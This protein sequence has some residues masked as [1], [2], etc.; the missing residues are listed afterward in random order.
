[1]DNQILKGVFY[2]LFIS[3]IVDF[4]Q[5]GYFIFVNYKLIDIAS[6]NNG[7][8]SFT[9]FILCLA[10]YALSDFFLIANMVKSIRS[11]NLDIKLLS[12]VLVNGLSFL[13]LS[14]FKIILKA[15]EFKSFAPPYASLFMALGAV[16]SLVILP[17]IWLYMDAITRKYV[18]R[19]NILDFE[20]FEIKEESSLY[21]TY[22]CF[23]K[24]ELDGKEIVL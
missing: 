9:R 13:S 16:I 3:K 22:K 20:I 4:A 6:L 12:G 11:N 7:E 14:L 5:F 1:M 8:L 2:F 19:K 21:P 10:F 17:F 24:T 18:F 15:C 23:Y